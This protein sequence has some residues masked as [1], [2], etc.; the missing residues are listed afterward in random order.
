MARKK[1]WAAAGRAAVRC[2]SAMVLHGQHTCPQAS[3][4]PAPPIKDTAHT[5]MISLHAHPH[6]STHHAASHHGVPQAGGH[7]CGVQV[8]RACAG[9]GSN[10][11]T[12][13][14]DKTLTRRV[15][16]REDHIGPDMATQDPGQLQA[17]SQ[18]AP[19]EEAPH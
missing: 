11:K 6:L 19:Q 18:S 9:F 16:T 3:R 12:T 1:D 8:A 17:T 7:V 13:Q 5:H 14:V 15:L 10:Q 4:G 2:V